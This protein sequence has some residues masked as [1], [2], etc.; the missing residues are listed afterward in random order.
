MGPRREVQ[1]EYSRLNSVRIGNSAKTS[2]IFDPPILYQALVALMTSQ[3]ARC[4]WL[5]AGL[6]DVALI[7]A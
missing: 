7:P 1:T 3:G 4:L 2:P 5:A 6:E